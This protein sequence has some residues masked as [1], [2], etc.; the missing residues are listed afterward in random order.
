M[1]LISVD[2]DKQLRD[3]GLLFS[4]VAALISILLLWKGSGSWVF[5]ALFSGVFLILGLFA[6]GILSPLEKIWMKFGQIMSGVMTKLIVGIT[7]FL[8]LTP[9]AFLMKL[10]GKRPLQLSPDKDATSYWK[11]VDQG[12]CP[13]SRPYSPF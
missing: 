4:L 11:A 5:S 8:V 13:G 12:N 2:R 9:I 10:F 7:Y 1:S 3:F 6:P